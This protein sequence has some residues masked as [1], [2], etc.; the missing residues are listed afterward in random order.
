LIAGRRREQFR[1]VATERRR[2]TRQPGYG[3]IAFAGF[4][5]IDE[6]RRER[7]A[8]GQGAHRQARVLPQAAQARAHAFE[9]FSFL[10][11]RVHGGLHYIA[12][13]AGL[14]LAI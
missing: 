6:A 2:H 1:D 8:V 7:R 3:N 5:L 9:E 12:L 4:E 11:S 14:Q 10:I 13:S